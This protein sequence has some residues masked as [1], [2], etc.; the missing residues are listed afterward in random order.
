[1]RRLSPRFSAARRSV[2]GTSAALLAGG[3][4]PAARAAQQR[5]VSVGGALTEIVYALQAERDLVGV[6]ST[7]LYPAMAQQLPIVGYARTLSAEGVLALAPTQ[8]LAT[9]EAGPP[10]VIRQIA[11]AGVPVTVLPAKHRFEGLLERVQRVGAITGRTA[12]AKALADKLNADWV[13]TQAASRVLQNKRAQRPLRVLFI[14]A[15]SPSQIMVGGEGTA[16]EAMIAY[17]GARNAVQGFEGYKPL[18]P[19]AAIVADPDVILLTRQGLDANGGIEG[20]LRLPGVA[21]TAAG[22]AR[23]VVSLEAMYLLGFGPRLPQAVGE[24]AQLL[25]KAAT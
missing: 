19:E 4:L 14:L 10:A 9:E 8:L 1:M 2:L 5:I 17:A 22:R 21:Q 3:L 7:S 6:D 15:H 24:L 25:D 11:A 12:A 16:A 20:V 23:R 18:T 13:R